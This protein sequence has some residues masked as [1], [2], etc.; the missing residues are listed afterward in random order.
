[1][2]ISQLDQTK[3][4]GSGGS[5]GSPSGP[6][7]GVLAGTYP[8]PTFAADMATQAELDAGLALKA[9]DTAVMHLTGNETAAGNKT[10][11]SPLV[12]S[13]ASLSVGTTPAATGT[14]RLPN[15][16]YVYGRNAA[17]DANVRMLSLDT[18][19]NIGIGSAGSQL[20]LQADYT[21]ILDGKP[22]VF[23][24]TLGTKIAVSAAQKLAFWGKA[25]IQQPTTA[26]A[27]AAFVA[28][29]GTAI[30]D[31]STFDGYTVKQVVAALRAV[32]ILA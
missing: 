3:L 15:S 19:N 30:N 31:A 18:N 9:T 7:G 28:N 24:T 11:S 10:F 32:G 21:S 17:N 22:I 23:G 20:E 25:P 27:P 16:S 13:G 1:M 8:A 12:V 6:A 14:I 2:A 26:Q 4:I 5:G 29:T